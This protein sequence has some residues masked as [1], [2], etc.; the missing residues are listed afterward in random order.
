MRLRPTATLVLAAATA[1]A[2]LIISLG[3][4]YD[5]AALGLGFI[6][7]R[8]MVEAPWPALPVWLTPLH[9]SHPRLLALHLIRCTSSIDAIASP[10]G[11][12]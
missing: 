9:C 10:A 11:L 1:A 12:L 3:R 6:P 8:L 4:L 2:F 5:A 7:A